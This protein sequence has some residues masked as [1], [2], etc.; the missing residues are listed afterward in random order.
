MRRRRIR[1]PAWQGQVV[2]VHETF[3]GLH[4]LEELQPEPLWKKDYYEVF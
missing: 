2:M 3:M 1:V 4:R